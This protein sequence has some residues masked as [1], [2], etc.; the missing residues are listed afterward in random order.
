MNLALSA[1]RG[2]QLLGLL[3]LAIV[4][5]T[6][7]TG[8]GSDTPPTAGPREVTCEPLR[9]F[10]Q[11]RY[12][13][14]VTLAVDPHD[15]PQA[16][17]SF[18]LTLDIDGAIQGDDRREVIVRYPEEPERD[19]AIV[20]IGDKYWDYV[21]E[22][23]TANDVTPG[24]AAI[25]FLPIDLCTSI[26]PDIATTGQ[27]PVREKVNG[28]DTLKYHFDALPSSFSGRLWGT[29]SDMGQYIKVYSV[30]IW[31]HEKDNWPVRF[32]LEGGGNYE[33]GQALRA[34]VFL[35]LRDINDKNIKIEPPIP[36]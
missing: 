1:K 22:S 26:A 19:L 9:E 18:V 29:T 30:D 16:L 21:A 3:L 2:A 7:C 10:S 28:F 32:D 8:G 35:E 25:P 12:N 23:W 34:A 33:N 15:D 4:V 6:A 17:N 31:I 27:T 20:W 36:E 5:W 13:T 11:Y 14:I 24:V